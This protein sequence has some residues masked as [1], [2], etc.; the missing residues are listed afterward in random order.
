MASFAQN[1]GARTPEESAQV[2]EA[3]KF[4]ASG[5]MRLAVTEAAYDEGAKHCF[6]E[7]IRPRSTRKAGSS[8][9]LHSSNSWMLPA[10]PS[11]TSPAWMENARKYGRCQYG[12]N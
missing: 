4:G 6:G 3:G 12:R 7:T 11:S 9:P 2:M 10:S 8:C 1:L 5:I